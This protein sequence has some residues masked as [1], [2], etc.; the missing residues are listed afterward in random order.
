MISL[1]FLQCL[2]WVSQSRHFEKGHLNYQESLNTLKKDI[3]TNLDKIYALNSWYGSIFFN[4]LIKSLNLDTLKKDISTV[5]KFW[6]PQKRTSQ[7]S[8]KS[9]HF[10]KDILTNIE[11]AYALK[12][13]IVFIFF[14]VS[15]KSLNLDTLKN[16]ILTVK[17]VSTILKRT[18][19]Q[20]LKK[21]MP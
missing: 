12:S 4:V 3:L 21:L 11:E 6:T 2:N 20:I 7:V 18:S 1:D 5:K 19:W 13:W 8:R 14:N 10:K 9:W 17:K 16:N 15:I